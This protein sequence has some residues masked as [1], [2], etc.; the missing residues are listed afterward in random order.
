[1]HTA[2]PL[3]RMEAKYNTVDW[4]QNETAIDGFVS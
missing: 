2:V 3:K 1:M 4:I